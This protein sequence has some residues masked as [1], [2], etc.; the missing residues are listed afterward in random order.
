LAQSLEFQAEEITPIEIAQGR[1]MLSI[2][3]DDGLRVETTLETLGA[4]KAAFDQEG[5]ITAGNS[6]QITDG[7]ATVILMSEKEAKARGIQ[8]IA[9]VLATALVAGPDFSLAAQPANAINAVLSKSSKTSSDLV[10]AE[11]NEAFAA[12]AVHSTRLL[13]L[14]PEIVNSNGGAIALGHPIGASGARIVGHL[15]R[16]LQALGSGA[17]G[18]A[19]ICGGGGQGSAILLEAI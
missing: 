12:V 6:S 2:S 3:S 10:A 4:L 8:G 7:A 18:A 1:E 9:R 5:T 19:G 17:I 14:D 15:A 11:I 16:R 13:N